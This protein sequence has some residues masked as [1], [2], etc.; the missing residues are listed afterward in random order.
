MQCHGCGNNLLPSS[1]PRLS[2]YSDDSDDEE[3]MLYDDWQGEDH[4]LKVWQQ[5]CR[6]RCRECV[7]LQEM[8]EA[9]KTHKCEQ[10]NQLY[11]PTSADP[12]CVSCA[13]WRLQAEHWCERCK[14]NHAWAGVRF[15]HNELTG[16][17]ADTTRGVG[18]VICKGCGPE[19][20][21]LHCYACGVHKLA[22]DFPKSERNEPE[23]GDIIRR[24][25]WACF[26]CSRCTRN[27]PARE[28]FKARS[29]ARNAP[30]TDATRARRR[31]RRAI[32]TQ[33]IYNGPNARAARRCA[34]AAL[35]KDGL[36]RI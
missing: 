32:S 2:W 26:T 3:T 22:L 36:L 5:G 28:A 4:L 21:S 15:L 31:C 7:T 9:T 18:R 33:T 29:I 20:T 34:S 11:T 12:V 17:D 35:R 6:R 8:H 10:C 13:S 30:T 27:T 19:F 1:Y 24:R 23:K 25:C 16:E 14:K